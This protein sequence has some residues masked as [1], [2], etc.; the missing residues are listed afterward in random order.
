MSQKTEILKAL[1][2]GRKLTSLDALADF[3]CFRLGARIL[4][5]HYMGYNI[6]KRTVRSS[7]GKNFTQYRLE[8]KK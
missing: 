3:G 6:L 7:N 4:E 5:I 8:V 2:K 1:K